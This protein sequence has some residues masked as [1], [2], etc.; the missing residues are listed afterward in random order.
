VKLSSTNRLRLATISVTT[1][2]TLGIG[3]F[4]SF[5][6][7][8]NEQ[9]RVDALIGETVQ[10]AAQNPGQELSAALFYIDQYS[11]DLSLHLLSR[12]GQLT[13]ISDSA[14]TGFTQLSLGE[15]AAAMRD[16]HDGSMKTHYRLLTLEI[17]GGD[18]LVVVG[19]VEDVYKRLM[20]NLAAAV[21]I[22][23]VANLFAFIVLSLYI[24]RLKRRDDGVALAR[25]QEFLGDASHELRTPLTVIKGYVEMLSK[26]MMSQESDKE[27]A[28]LRV[29]HEIGRMEDLIHDLLLLAEL[30]ESGER[31]KEKINLSELLQSH[32]DDF[33]ALNPKRKV[34]VVI[35]SEIE[36]DAVRDYLVRY[37]QNTL[38]NITRHTPSDAPVKVVLARKGKGVRLAIEDGGPGLPDTAYRENIRSLNRFDASRSREHGGSGLGM[39][40][41]AGVVAKLG[42]TLSL[43]RSEL[44]GLA[45]IAQL[46]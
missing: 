4:A 38:V 33:I 45:V 13:T 40:I 17:S 10:A 2:L 25:M 8:N 14:R 9:G 23:L 35:E 46:P 44:G 34:E 21:V 20:A 24:R 1:F 29:N 12:D 19:S 7:Y 3:L 32:A 15:A 18:Y 39:S 28:F 42:G 43:Q 31:G 26:G 41:M 5:S 37:I 11:L 36:I 30:G 22:T 27:R 6:T 16:I